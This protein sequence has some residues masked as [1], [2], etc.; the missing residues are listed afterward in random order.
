MGPYFDEYRAA[1]YGGGG[2]VEKT[3]ELIAN[4]Y[5]GANPRFDYTARPFT[6]AAIH[7]NG[8]YRYDADFEKIFPRA[9]LGTY[10][11]AWG[12]Y[13]AEE[14][15]S[16]QFILIPRGPVKILMNGETVYATTVEAERY[17]DTPVSIIL[18]V[19]P[20][21]NHL[22]LRFTRTKAGFGA[23][24]GTWLGKLDYYFFRGLSCPGLPDMEGFDYTAPLAR[25]LESVSAVSLAPLCLPRPQWPA[26]KK[27]LGCFG[28]IFGS[29]GGVFPDGRVAARTLIHVPV[30][31]RHTLRG[32]STGTCSLYLERRRIFPAGD[33]SGKTPPANGGFRCECTLEAGLNHLICIAESPAGGGPWDF[34][35]EAESSDGS[36]QARFLNPFFP[37]TGTGKAGGEAGC[38]EFSWIY[39]G[40]FRDTSEEELLVFDRELLP[41][42]RGEQTWWRIDMPGGWVRLYNENPLYGHWN[43]PLGVTLYGL[44]ET[45]RYFDLRGKANAIAAYVEDHVR[46]SIRT[47]D[48]A[49]FDK[50]HFGGATAVHHLLTSIDSLDDCGSFGSLVMEAARDGRIGG[51][52]TAVD[53]AGEHIL[54]KQDRLPGGV[55][56]RKNQMHRFH[57]ETLWADDLYMSVPFLCRYARLKEDPAILDDAARQFE[58]FKKYLFMEDQG[59][60]AHVYDVR[61]AKN[62]GVPWGR[63]NGWTIFSLSELL[64]ALPEDH[65]KRDFLTG[66]F[67]TLAA[68]CLACQDEQGMWRQVLNMPSSY[69]ETSCTAMFICAFCRGIRRR[70]FSEDASSYRAAAEKAWKALE[71][72]SVDRGGNIYGVCR[73]SEFAFNPRYYAEHLLPRLNDTHGIGIVLLAGVELLKLQEDHHEL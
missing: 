11:Y 10:V 57:N 2:S 12:K 1:G 38:R 24:F 33:G 47:L 62:T 5:I 70:W 29:S 59:L 61:R 54:H 22:V 45:A 64:L 46:K 21:W 48:Y 50:E 15:G 32:F 67:R 66:F 51:H 26:E 4:R 65:P 41:G 7:R 49:L 71:R 18:P 53:Y 36:V 31:S 37:E 19:E 30:R 42:R 23:E 17:A 40:P 6:T 8:T 68:G 9:P 52:E 58:G 56:Y 34:S 72:F 43:Y 35:L 14:K 55:F 28:R 27:A 69:P 63:G 39:A 73:G 60:M 20:G 16:L 3:L 13:R 44:M 25:P